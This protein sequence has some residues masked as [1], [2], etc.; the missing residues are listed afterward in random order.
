LMLYSG[1]LWPIV[2]TLATSAVLFLAW[3]LPR[4]DTSTDTAEGDG[5]KE[6]LNARLRRITTATQIIADLGPNADLATTKRTMVEAGRLALDTEMVALFTID[7]CTGQIESECTDGVTETLQ[8][9]FLDLFAQQLTDRSERHAWIVTDAANI[10]T[11]NKEA[12]G[13]LGDCGICTVLACPIR[14]ESSAAGAIVGFYTSAV[15]QPEERIYAIEALSAQASTALSYSLSLEQS[16]FML[17]DLAG[18]NQEL[19][20]QATVDGLTGLPNHRT[21]Q[22][23]LT[24]L[25]R[26]TLGKSGRPFCVVM[27]DVDNFKIY[28]DT[29]GHREGDSVLRKVSKTMA[30]GLRQGD[31]AARYGGEEF[32][33]IFQRADREAAFVAADRIRRSIAEQ[34]LHKGI[35]TVSMGVAEFP[36]DAATPGELIERADKALYHAKATGRNRVFAWGTLGTSTAQSPGEKEEG[37]NRTV[38]VVEQAEEACAGVVTKTL[39]S[40]SCVVQVVSSLTEAAELLKTRVFDIALVSAEALPDRDTKSLS[41]LAAIHPHMPI[42]LLADDMPAQESREALRRGATDILLKPYNPAELPVVIERNLERQRL[43]LQRLMQK[44]TGVMLQAIDAL[45]AAIDA[46]DHHTGGH[47]QGVTALS[48]ALCDEL[49]ISNEERYALELAAKLHDIG[50]VALPDSALNKESPLTEG[51]WLAMR[52]H[53][54][55]GAKIVGAINELAYVSTIIRHHHERLDGTGYPDG[56]SGQAIPYLSRVIAVADAYEAMTSERAHRSRLTPAEAIA[57]I[58]RNSGTYYQPEVVDVLERQLVA[59]GDITVRSSD[60]KAA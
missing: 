48:V 32:A 46:K 54:S 10:E 51:E 37:R 38:L 2:G 15:P 19:S 29:Y 60:Q 34:S 4:P 18:A 6:S 49:R 57:E 31:L 47:S 12:A 7:P 44:S 43:E 27:V 3:R 23:A 56:L 52:E 33:M 20:V 8:Q 30:S 35:A 5:S 14:S 13:V 24:D 55:I 16:R 9:A 41:T 1:R 50:K 25:C 21:F 42:V 11:P 58:Q 22:Q 36:V 59:R 53:P 45:V 17:D 28:N 39:S 26:K 40:D